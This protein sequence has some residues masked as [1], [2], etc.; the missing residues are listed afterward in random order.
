MCMEIPSKSDF[1]FS[2]KSVKV[3]HYQCDI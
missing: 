1:A 2:G 3:I